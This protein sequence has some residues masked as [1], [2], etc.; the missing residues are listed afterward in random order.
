MPR[1]NPMMFITFH[2]KNMV[3]L[4]MNTFVDMLWIIKMKIIFLNS[5]ER[6]LKETK[7]IKRMKFSYSEYKFN[8]KML[9]AL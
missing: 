1:L 7:I 9:Q 3:Q 5:I 8:W 6:W 2:L 4:F